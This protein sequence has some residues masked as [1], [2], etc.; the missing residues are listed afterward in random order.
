ML[1]KNKAP[2]GIFKRKQEEVRGE[3]FH[4]E[5]LHNLFFF[6]LLLIRVMKPDEM[7]SM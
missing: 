6:F 2:R 5:E 1:C 4:N 7:F 3:K